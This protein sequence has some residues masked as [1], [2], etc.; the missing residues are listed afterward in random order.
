MKQNQKSRFSLVALGLALVM[1][2]SACGARV[3]TNLTLDENGAGT[4][5]IAFKVKN[6]SDAKE[7]INGGYEAIQAAIEKHLPSELEFSGINATDEEATG[8]FKL[9]FSSLDD[10]R[11]KVAS[12][13]AAG[14]MDRDPEITFYSADGILKKGVQYTENFT[15]TELLAWVPDALVVEGVI[16]S[17]NKSY[18]IDGEDAGT[19]TIGDKSFKQEYGGAFRINETKDQAFSYVGLEITPLDNDEFDVVIRMQRPKDTAA[20]IKKLD[21][22]FLASLGSDVEIDADVEST[23]DVYERTVSFQAASVDDLVKKIDTVYGEGTTQLEVSNE[24]AEGRAAIS[25]TYKGSVDPVQICAQN[26]RKSVTIYA[27]E[28][29]LSQYGDQQYFADY[30]GTFEAAFEKDIT[31]ESMDVALNVS[32]SAEWTMGIDLVV[33]TSEY[34]DFLDDVDALVTVPEEFGTV[35]SSDSD[36]ERTYSIKVS[37][38][39]DNNDAIVNAMDGY[40]DVH[41]FSKSEKQYMEG[42]Y[43]VSVSI[44]PAQLLGGVDT[45]AM[46]ARIELESGDKFVDGEWL[47]DWQIDGSTA[48]YSTSDSTYIAFEGAAFRHSIGKTIALIVIGVLLLAGAVLAYIYRKPLGEFLSRA[49]K[50]AKVASANATEHVKQASQSASASYA[51][52]MEQS[53]S[54]TDS[55]RPVAGNGMTAPGSAA[56]PVSTGMGAS[57]AD[58]VS[59]TAGVAD[60]SNGGVS[61]EAGREP[62]GFTEHQLT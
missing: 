56:V 21:D 11:E 41:E 24:K 23:T 52:A 4:R 18:V 17:S 46:T 7:K 16:D 33:D 25:R 38:S 54:G 32:P 47:N 19:L 34:A 59:T 27:P 1:L 31:F 2:L 26:C 36:G 22:E 39:A 12:I 14:G 10:Y 45:K 6:D 9:T 13:L 53:Q 43:V 40:I 61:S 44:D 60:A 30:S 49:G 5:T 50:S 3:T 29:F 42:D 48:T 8:N 55:A 20:P 51:T 35:S 58:A 37:A 15:S 28:G 57:P 62:H